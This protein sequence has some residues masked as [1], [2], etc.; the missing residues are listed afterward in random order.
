MSENLYPAFIKNLP[1]ADLPIEKVVGYLLQGNRGQICFFDF[2]PGVEVPE[3]SHGNKWGVVL[4]GEFSLTMGGEAK[5]IRKGE[6]YYI[7]AGVVHYATF[8]RSCKVMDFF[9]RCGSVSAEVENKIRSK[10]QL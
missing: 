1:E 10:S 2:E 4:E 5:R 3:H 6:S 9:G 8:D 7:P